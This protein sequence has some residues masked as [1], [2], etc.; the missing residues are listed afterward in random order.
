MPIIPHKTFGQPKNSLGKWYAKRYNIPLANNCFE[1]RNNGAVPHLLKWACTFTCPLTGNTFK[2]GQYVGS[3]ET[4]YSID[5]SDVVWYDRKKEAEHAAAARALDCL[6]F[7]EKEV[8][9]T[10]AVE[11]LLIRSCF[12][13]PFPLCFAKLSLLV[14]LLPCI[15]Y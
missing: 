8:L 2:S 10:Y 3:D 11:W 9:K 12:W 14:L 13:L 15:R 5:G 1:C 7:M 4:R 6:N